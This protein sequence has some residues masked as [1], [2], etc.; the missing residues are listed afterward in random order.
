MTALLD[1]PTLIRFPDPLVFLPAKPA[2]PVDWWTLAACHNQPKPDLFVRDGEK[3]KAAVPRIQPFVDA[4]CRR[5]PVR[6]ACYAD[7][8]EYGTWAG[9]IRNGRKN[10]RINLLAYPAR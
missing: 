8:A 5:C 9:E 7:P 1:R 3:T 2:W 4:Y 6:D 10:A